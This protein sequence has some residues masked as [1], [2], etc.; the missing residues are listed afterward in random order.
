M[1]VEVPGVEVGVAVVDDDF[2][3]VVVLYYYGVDLAI[4]EGVGDVFFWEGEGGVESRDFLAEVSFAVDRE[5]ARCKFMASA[6]EGE[7][8]EK[9]TYRLTPLTFCAVVSKII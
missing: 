5:A 3:D 8:K 7:E 6:T 9:N 4:D 1:A 2:D